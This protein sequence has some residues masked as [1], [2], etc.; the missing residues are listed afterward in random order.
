MGWASC[1]T[2]RVKQPGSRESPSLEPASAGAGLLCC[3]DSQKGFRRAGLGRDPQPAAYP[4]GPSSRGRP[5]AASRFVRWAGPAWRPPPPCLFPRPQ[6]PTR[7]SRVSPGSRKVVLVAMLISCRCSRV[8]VWKRR[9]EEPEEKAIQTPLPAF[10]MCVTLTA[11][12]WC[13]SKLCCGTEGALSVTGRPAEPLGTKLTQPRTQVRGRGPQELQAKLTQPR[14][15]V[16]GRGP[17][18]LRAKLT[19]PRTRVRERGCRSSGPSSPNPKPKSERGDAG[20]PG[21]AH[22]TLNRVRGR[23]LRHPRPS[24]PNPEPGQRE[25]T[26][27]PRAKLTQ[28]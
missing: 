20:T 3:G 14:T 24:S 21:Q 6:P 12:S 18:E 9:M 15:R 1:P 17:Q 16:R 7:D 5:K 28:P 2:W 4:E 25:G 23:G 27:T 8:S 10:T 26:Q 22:P 13:A 11:S 19:Q